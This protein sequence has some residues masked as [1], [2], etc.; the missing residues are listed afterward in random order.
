MPRLELAL[1]GSVYRFMLAQIQDRQSN[2][3]NLTLSLMSLFEPGCASAVATDKTSL[4]HRISAILIRRPFSGAPPCVQQ[5]ELRT[6]R[7]TT[8]WFSSA[9]VLR[10][11]V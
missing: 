1:G 8:A 3:D 9:G 10:L 11:I 6:V 7:R 5:R 4:R 2:A